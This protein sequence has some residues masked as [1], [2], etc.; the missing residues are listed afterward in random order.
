LL[1]R[2]DHTPQDPSDVV[3]ATA[4]G[5]QQQQQV[6]YSRLRLDMLHAMVSTAIEARQRQL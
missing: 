6:L 3:S 1:I 4:A 5:Q 2:G